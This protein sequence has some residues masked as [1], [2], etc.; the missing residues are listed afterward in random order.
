[1]ARTVDQAFEILVR[2]LTPSGTESAA[3]ATH[4]ATIR[5][6]L[7]S[8]FGMTALFRSGSYGH[9]TSISNYSDIDYFAVI[10]AGNL[11]KDS[12]YTLQKMKAALARRFP[13]TSI[14]VRNPAAV[15]P[16]GEKRSEVHEI[17][18]AYYVRTTKGHSVY[19]I[20]NR[21]TG[22]MAAS[23]KAHN[24]HVSKGHRRLRQ[25]LKPLIRLVKAWK[26]YRNVPIRSFYLELRVTE[27]MSSE[28]SIIYKYDVRSAFRHLLNV[29]LRAMQDPQGISGYVY[30]GS[31][32]NRVEALSKLDTALTRANNARV[33]E[34]RGAIQSA[35]EWWDKA[36]NGNFPAYY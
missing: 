28:K 20:P 35:F 14:V 11:S 17:I 18:P 4:R 16:F 3:A 2:R 10:P 36:F 25:K 24:V 22:W 33:V 7:H 8:N 5:A 9:G 23:P 13:K 1:M 19:G 27:A 31:E 15:V 32:P 34:K 30:P 26:Y 29:E 12:D 21:G 6:C